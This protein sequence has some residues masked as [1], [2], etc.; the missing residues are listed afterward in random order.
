MKKIFLLL[1]LVSFI[2]CSYSQAAE[3]S[4][5]EMKRIEKDAKNEAKKLE[6]QGWLASPGAMTIQRQLEK[7]FT[8]EMEKGQDGEE[9]YVVGNGQSVAKTY[10]AAK[11]QAIEMAKQDIAGKLQTEIANMVEISVANDQLDS[12][13]AES[14][15]RVISESTTFNKVNLGRLITVTELYRDIK[16]TKNKEVL[17]RVACNYNAAMNAAKEAVRKSLEDRGD[18]M[19]A[20]LDSML[21]K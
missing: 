11:K 5:K 20:K 18:K 8:M 10:D 4:K 17:V 21:N 16:G 14:V 7:A 19:R 13:D 12:E 1:T 9:L 2:C 15:T 6:S 3:L